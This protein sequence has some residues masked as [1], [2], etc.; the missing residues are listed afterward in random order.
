MVGYEILDPVPEIVV[1]LLDLSSFNPKR[2]GSISP[3]PPELD[4]DSK[5]ILSR[6]FT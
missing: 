3:P 4:V 5:A 2:A 6:I 1:V